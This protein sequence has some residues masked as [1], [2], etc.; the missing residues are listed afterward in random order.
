MHFRKQESAAVILVGLD[1]STRYWSPEAHKLFDAGPDDQSASS[2]ESSDNEDGDDLI[3][4]TNR[5]NAGD[6]HLSVA[7]LQQLA[8]NS[9]PTCVLKRRK[10][11]SELV[12]AQQVIVVRGDGE[13]VESDE[14]LGDGVDGVCGRDDSTNAIGYMIKFYD[15]TAL[16]ATPPAP[17]HLLHPRLPSNRLSP[18]TSTSPSTHTNPTTIPIPKPPA[19][20]HPSTSILIDNLVKRTYSKTGKHYIHDLVDALCTTLGTLVA[21]VGQISI[22]QYETHAY[23]GNENVVSTTAI[24]PDVPNVN[25]VKPTQP[26]IGG[27]DSHREESPSGSSSEEESWRLGLRGR[28]KNGHHGHGPSRGRSGPTVLPAGPH[29]SPSYGNSSPAPQLKSR[30]QSPPHHIPFT[31]LASSSSARIR[32]ASPT[33]FPVPAHVFSR[34]ASSTSGCVNIKHDLP[35]SLPQ[36][37]DVFPDLDLQSAC[38]VALRDRKGR[39]VG[40]VGVASP[41][42][43]WVFEPSARMSSPAEQVL[44]ALRPRIQGELKRNNELMHMR[45]ES[46]SAIAATK[47]KTHFLANM[48]HEIRTPVSAIIGLTDM[49]LWDA[50][51]IP[52]EHRNKLE[53]ISSSGE[54]LLAVIND[55]LDLSKIGDEDVNF[56]LQERTMGIRRCL[57]EAVQ[58][59]SMSPYLAKKK[60]LVVDPPSSPNVNLSELIAQKQKEAPG[61]LPLCWRVDP[62]VPEFIIGDVTRLRQVVL[63]LLSNALKFTSVGSV[64]ATVTRVQDAEL[65]VVGEGAGESGYFAFEG[66]HAPKPKTEREGS[67]VGLGGIEGQ[68]VGNSSQDRVDAAPL[69]GLGSDGI[70]YEHSVASSPPSSATLMYSAGTDSTTDTSLAP[71]PRY[72]T[73]LFTVVDT[74]CGVPREKISRLF[75]PFSQIDNEVT[76]GSGVGTGLGLAISSRLVE[77]MGG[78][79]WVESSEGVGSKFAF[80]VRFQV[81]DGAASGSD[82][83]GDR[84]GSPVLGAAKASVAE[85]KGDDEGLQ[86]PT[87]PADRQSQSSTGKNSMGERMPE[88]N[89]GMGVYSAQS[90][91]RLKRNAA[92]KKNLANEYPIRILIAEDNMIN[93]QIA[94]SVLKKMGY[95]ADVAANGKEVLDKIDAGKQYDL[96]LMDVCMPFLDG[97]ECTRELVARRKTKPKSGTST[98]N[99]GTPTI[100]PP[101]FITE[102]VDDGMIIIAL[103]AS[104]T[105]DDKLKCEDA[106]MHDWLSKPFKALELQDKIATHFGHMKTADGGNLERRGSLTSN[107]SGS[108]WGKGL[109]DSLEASSRSS[110]FASFDVSGPGAFMER[111]GSLVG[112]D[113]GGVAGKSEDSDGV[114]F[115]ASGSSGGIDTASSQV[116]N[117]DA[118][119]SASTQTAAPPQTQS[120]EDIDPLASVTPSVPIDLPLSRTN[121]PR[122]M[123][124]PATENQSTGSPVPPAESPI[125]PGSRLAALAAEPLSPDSG[126]SDDMPIIKGQASAILE[127]WA[128][129]DP[130]AM[131]G[132]SNDL[133]KARSFI[134]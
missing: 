121:R 11:G 105:T 106:G 48:S 83:D 93:Q 126:K 6:T 51:A 125:S 38:L 58:L 71:K 74:G 4:A 68:L 24:P 79:I 104:A 66:C 131:P 16:S 49:V 65:S 57:K 100:T 64:T 98:N 95:D 34:L 32:S 13:E 45:V 14:E 92:I 37:A 91:T 108:S 102:T 118:S 40:V 69:S 97:L 27:L 2:Q 73:L 20:Q 130:S 3:V 117:S 55:I 41:K 113:T 115:T 94:L 133:V 109:A 10:D 26:I 54:H 110:S 123:P 80:L 50:E 31:L 132:G 30:S 88:P 103:T 17:I 84:A 63:N 127:R 59:A 112:S 85:D 75:I 90:L 134:E 101:A 39:V 70:E 67:V 111:S 122:F 12:V 72:A 7:D 77:M 124:P 35:S 42:P 120:G 22:E 9:G 116:D 99:P 18:S 52:E 89:P 21:F 128:N 129:R 114:S 53:L 15:I 76:R 81:A 33:V 28:K 43:M 23:L 78:H 119:T 8:G 36:A 1:G 44:E 87:T 5:P 86:V 46:A 61:A 107:G 29:R 62:S 47:S 19:P 82:S 60:I 96:I 25:V 56:T